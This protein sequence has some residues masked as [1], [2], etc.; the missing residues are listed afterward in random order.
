MTYK[1][2]MNI[3]KQIMVEYLQVE[4]LWSGAT[5]T[6]NELDILVACSPH[7][8]EALEVV[9]WE[10]AMFK[11]ALNNARAQKMKEERKAWN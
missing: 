7:V 9:E 3:L 8:I 4:G 5:L 2:A 11:E 6:P 10:P 1:E